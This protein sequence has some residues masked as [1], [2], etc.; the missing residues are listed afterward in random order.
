MRWLCVLAA[1]CSSRAAPPVADEHRAAPPAARDATLGPDDAAGKGDVQIRV[2]WQDVPAAAR[3][4]PGRTPCGTARAGAVAPTT[5]WGIPDVF[6][7]LDLAGAP[8]DA[9][10]RVA[11]D[12]CALVPRAI[13]AGKRLEIAST[14]EA[15]DLLALTRR[16]D[17]RD[18]SALVDGMP[19]PIQ[20]PIAG[21]T[22]AVD[23]DVGGLYELSRAGGDSAW[24][25]AAS[26]PFVAVTEASGQVVL[27]DVPTGHY[28]VTAWLPPRAGQPA[29]TGHAEATVAAG[30]L[31]EVTVDLAK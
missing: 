24:I 30:A 5:T 26:E 1:A 27:R 4:S 18:V 28:A 29:R 11:L 2:E 3:S 9:V 14:A 15:P 22:V 7:V 6:V 20:L 8:P 16:G 31:A 19:R 12:H 25:V 10:A 13:V 23:L 17:L 21:H